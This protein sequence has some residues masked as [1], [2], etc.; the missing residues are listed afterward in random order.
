MNTFDINDSLKIQG[1]YSITFPTFD[2]PYHNHI[3]YEIMLVLDG[4]CSVYFLENESE[5]NQ[6]TVVNIASNQ[7]LFINRGVIH[8]LLVDNPDQ[9][10]LNVEFILSKEN[11]CFNLSKLTA[12][13]QN[14]TNLFR[15]TEPFFII[16]NPEVNTVM[17][18]LLKEL[19]S[20]REEDK[21]FM[22][23]LL[24]C[25]LLLAIAREKH[26][27]LN[28]NF[29]PHIKHAC[30][31]IY[32]NFKNKLS[33]SD[34]ASY[35]KIS[36]SYLQKLFLQKFHMGVNQFII[37]YRLSH[38]EKLISKNIPINQVYHMSGFQSRQN[39]EYNFKKKFGCSATNYSRKQQTQ[40]T[41]YK[42]YTVDIQYISHPL[43][44]ENEI[45]F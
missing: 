11:T 13:S 35:C 5:E 18:N 26:S 38:A 39:F 10:I 3:S 36:V 41:R 6:E 14:L 34:V 29:M 42:N 1:F 22:S 37:D 31:F 25:Q 17:Q 15:K 28:Q 27:T 9:K 32:S 33:I 12:L 30:K 43:L 44:H 40:N 19:C 2:M 21:S 24:L 7:L 4:C 16:E 23:H 20:S 8:R 45:S